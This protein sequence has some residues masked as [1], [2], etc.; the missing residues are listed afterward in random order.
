MQGH[1]SGS[2]KYPVPEADNAHIPEKSAGSRYGYAVSNV[3]E[4]GRSFGTGFARIPPNRG[5][6]VSETSVEK[7]YPNVKPTVRAGVKTA[8]PDHQPTPHGPGDADVPWTR[9][10]LSH[11]SPT[12]VLVNTPTPAS[13][14]TARQ[15]TPTTE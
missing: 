15:H 7:A 11:I 3:K 8:N 12:I 4:G 9:L 2:K 13:K 10:V 14:P 5:L 1:T 6:N